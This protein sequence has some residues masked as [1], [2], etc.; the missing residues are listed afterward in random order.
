MPAEVGLVG[1]LRCVIVQVETMG[2]KGAFGVLRIKTL[3]THR[4]DQGRRNYADPA[5]RVSPEALIGKAERVG[6]L[7][8]GC[9]RGCLPVV[10]GLT[11]RPT[12]S[13]PRDGVHAVPGCAQ[14]H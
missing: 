3:D 2:I 4:L 9:C 6:F 12:G 7:A 13:A 1:G 11:S 14:V 8:A 5:G 10:E